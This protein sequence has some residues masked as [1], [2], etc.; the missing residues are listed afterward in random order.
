MT[1]RG[2]QPLKRDPTLSVSKRVAERSGLYSRKPIGGLKKYPGRTAPTTTTGGE[3]EASKG[4]GGDSS[5]DDEMEGFEEKAKA[6]K[7]KRE[8]KEKRRK[9]DKAPS[10]KEI[11]EWI[12]HMISIHTRL[13][14]EEDP[15]IF[16][17]LKKSRKKKGSAAKK[18]GNSEVAS[19]LI[20]NRPIT[21]QGIP[22]Y[23]RRASGASCM[24]LLAHEANKV[25]Q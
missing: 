1:Y 23:S 7:K 11:R 9:K 6:E 2:I 13:K 5:D 25:M 4:G 15:S 19:G 12:E 14:E 16:P 24:Y 21:K 3:G 8:D 22:C 10:T 18:G 20:R 17:I